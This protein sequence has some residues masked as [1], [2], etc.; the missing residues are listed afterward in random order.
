MVRMPRAVIQPLPQETSAGGLA[1][2]VPVLI[3]FSQQFPCFFF[4]L[5]VF[6]GHLYRPGATTSELQNHILELS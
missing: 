2:L 1:L 3:H 6:K 4:P 5:A